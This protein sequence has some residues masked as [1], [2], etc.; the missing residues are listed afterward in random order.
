MNMLN[1]AKFLSGGKKDEE[2]EL[3]CLWQGRDVVNKSECMC[4]RCLLLST[5]EDEVGALRRGARQ[6]L[7]ALHL[8]LFTLTLGGRERARRRL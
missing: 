4:V 2:Q 3:L 1:T 5:Q 8:Q 7:G 6:H